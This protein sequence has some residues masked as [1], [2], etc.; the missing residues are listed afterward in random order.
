MKLKYYFESVDMGDENVFV[1]VGDNANELHGVLKLNS[2]G[3]EIVSFL[4][5]DTTE[6]NIVSILSEKY[7]N[8][9]ET[10]ATYVHNAIECLRKAGLIE[11]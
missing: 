11:E 8:E 6:E 10:L 2:S 4:E 9:H 5:N 3:K 1:P 7:G